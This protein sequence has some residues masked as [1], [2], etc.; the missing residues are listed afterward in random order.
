MS[1]WE[2]QSTVRVLRSLRVG[3]PKVLEGVLATT[4]SGSTQQRVGEATDEPGRHGGRTPSSGDWTAV[5]TLD[6]HDNLDCAAE[7]VLRSEL[8]PPLREP[9]RKTKR[10]LDDEDCAG[11]DLVE[12]ESGLCEWVEAVHAEAVDAQGLFC[13]TWRLE[14][15]SSGAA[16]PCVP[17]LSKVTT[18]QRHALPLGRI[19]APAA[20][21]PLCPP[22]L[23]S[24]LVSNARGRQSTLRAL[25]CEWVLPVGAAFWLSRLS[26]WGELRAHMPAGGYRLLLMDPPWH[27]RSAQRARSYATLDKRVLLE[28]LPV[29]ELA[30]GEGCIVAVWLTNSRHVL[31]FV[32]DVLFPR[33]GARRIGCWLWLKLT[34]DGRFSTGAQPRDGHRKPWEPLLLGYIGGGP[35]PPLPPRLALCSVPTAHSRKPPIDALLSP[36]AGHLLRRAGAGAGAA[37]SAAT[38]AGAALGAD[39]TGT[40]AA[41]PGAIGGDACACAG[42]AMGEAEAEAWRALPKLELFARELRPHWHSVGDEVLH[43]QHRGFFAERRVARQARDQCSPAFGEVRSG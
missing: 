21:Q 37:M 38:G 16:Q 4:A 12:N 35:P 8:F 32:E 40:L 23:F 30:C 31:R 15:A 39:A 3:T 43:F 26:R 33:W 36:A 1:V 11:L 7:L 24:A 19:R 22:L 17:P 42:R 34:A 14:A 41:G 20:S 5:D 9:R 28:Q 18:A 27:C 25:G 2:V 29:T 13:S 6:A 10:P